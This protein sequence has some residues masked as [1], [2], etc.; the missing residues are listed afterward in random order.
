[1]FGAAN[2]AF[3]AWAAQYEEGTMPGRSRSRHETWLKQRRCR[4][5]RFDGDRPVHERVNEV[6]AIR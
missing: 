3:L 2:P 5:V 1:M 6:M 4:V